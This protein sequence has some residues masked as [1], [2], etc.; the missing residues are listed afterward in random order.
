MNAQTNTAPARADEAA[1][2]LAPTYLFR[3]ATDLAHICR[4]A[5]MKS[6]REIAGRNYLE[7]EGWIAIAWASGFTPSIKLVE[8]TEKGIRAVA[9]LKRDTDGA[10]LSSAEGFV[11]RDEPDWYGG[12]VT[13]LDKKSRTPTMKTF[14]LEKRNDHAI[15]AMAQTR[16]IS[17]VVCNKYRHVVRLIDAGLSTVPAEEMAG[18]EDLEP[19]TPPQQREEK[20]APDGGSK[21]AAD[22]GKKET[23]AGSKAAPEVPRD[24]VVKLR[25]QFRGGKWKAVVIHF[26]EKSKGKT[27]GEIE[28]K[29]LRWWVDDWQPKPFG[30]HPIKQEDLL[31]RAALDVAGEEEKELD[32]VRK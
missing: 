15:R 1:S 13:R 10:E 3:Q 14:T 31:L 7:V 5:V 25:E 20:K 9:V 32:A 18:A 16:A 8:E 17:R 4:D 28:I 29:S 21:P 26:G 27:I 23:G 12:T 30:N 11:G 19:Q 6:V 22:E 2:P 24:D